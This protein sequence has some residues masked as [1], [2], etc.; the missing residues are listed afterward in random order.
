[1]RLYLVRLCCIEYFLKKC[2][3]SYSSDFLAV[4]FKLLLH[5]SALYA[6][7]HF[8]LA[9]IAVLRLPPLHLSAVPL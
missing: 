4:R 7:Q 6:R 1:M 5:F 9:L 3:V 2:I 8:V